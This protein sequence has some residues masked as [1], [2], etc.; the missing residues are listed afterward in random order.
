MHGC[1]YNRGSGL[2][3]PYQTRDVFIN[4]FIEFFKKKKKTSILALSLCLLPSIQGSKE[5][6]NEYGEMI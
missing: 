4:D 6:W 1:F 5:I 3:C 2:L